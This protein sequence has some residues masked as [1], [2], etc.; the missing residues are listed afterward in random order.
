MG[1]GSNYVPSFSFKFP[2]PNS[3]GGSAGLL[4]DLEHELVIAPGHFQLYLSIHTFNSL[5]PVRWG[6]NVESVIFEVILRIKLMS[7]S[8]FVG[9]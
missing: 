6:G 1:M 9:W 4:L 8:L 2:Q 3:D 5:V 7:T